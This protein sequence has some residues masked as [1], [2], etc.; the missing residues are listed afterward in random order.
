MLLLLAAAII[1]ALILMWYVYHKDTQPEPTR[2]IVK[3]FCYGGIS[4]LVSTLISGPLLNM[5]FY[6]TDPKNLAEAIKIAFFGA[7]IPEESAKLL[8]LWLLLRHCPEFN[9]RFDGIVYATTI[10]LGFAAFENLL[11]LISAGASWVDVAFTRALTAIPGHFAFAVAMGY[12]YSLYHFK[13]KNAPAGTAVKIL[14][15]PIIFHGVYDTL[16][17]FTELGG[18]WT[19]VITIVLIFFCFKLFTYTRNRILS[20][21]ANNEYLGSG[22]SVSSNGYDTGEDWTDRP[23]DQ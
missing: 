7:A 8:M 4:A 17:F 15:V 22:D 11:Y 6:T 2:L 14:L 21:S 16:C 20:E 18:G 5:G 19:T 12:Y 1:P 3:G 13:G 23:D 10:G 9:E